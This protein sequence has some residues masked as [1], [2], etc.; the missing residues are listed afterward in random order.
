MALTRTMLKAMSL[1]E[2]KIDQIIDAHTSVVDS[3]KAE[4]DSLKEENSTLRE[5]A[6][7]VPSLQ[8]QLEEIKAS[9]PSEDVVAQYEALKKEYDDFK[10]TTEREKAEAERA[11]LYRSLLRE[12]GVDEKRLDAIM[13]VTDLSTVAVE[14]GAIKDKETVVEAIGKEWSD[15]IA[16]EATKGASVDTPPA[17]SAA[18]MDKEAILEIKD[19]QARQKAIAENIE[20][21]Q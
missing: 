3:L 8:K 21:F 13:K 15:F 17:N 11:S 6:K 20:Q 19:T 10:A 2:E 16:K 14:D 18:K 5:Q 7:E 12:A 9:I 1:E 4:R